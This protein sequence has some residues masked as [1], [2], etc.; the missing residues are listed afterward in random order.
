[1]SAFSRAKTASTNSFLLLRQ[2]ECVSVCSGDDRGGQQRGCNPTMQQQELN[3][4]NRHRNYVDDLHK[5]SGKPALPPKSRKGFYEAGK[6]EL[7]DNPR[8]I[9]SNSDCISLCSNFSYCSQCTNTD[10]VAEPTS[11]S[12]SM[13][14]LPPLNDEDSLRF[15][16]TSLFS[17]DSVS[18]RDFDFD[19]PYLEAQRSGREYSCRSLRPEMSTLSSVSSVTLQGD[20]LSVDTISLPEDPF[21]HGLPSSASSTIGSPVSSRY[22][23]STAL[24]L[25]WVTPMPWNAIIISMNNWIFHFRSSFSKSWEEDD[26]NALPFSQEEPNEEEKNLTKVG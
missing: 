17:E 13:S 23:Y 18:L 1:M 11:A 3:G 4:L 25:I 22:L 5:D 6:E 14:L 12:A 15:S 9:M 19:M 24:M 7:Y 2:S 8:H 21:P 20:D 26:L 16:P 10:S